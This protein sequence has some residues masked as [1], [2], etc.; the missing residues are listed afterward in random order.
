MDMRTIEIDVEVHK[1]IEMERAS[2]AESPNAV[3]RR[4]LGIDRPGTGRLKEDIAPL[5]WAG[6]GVELP[7]GTELTM[8]YNGRIHAG[9][10]EDGAWVVE[11]GRF[12]SPSAAAKAVART[13]GGAQPTLDGWRYWRVRRPGD[14]GWRRLR[15]LRGEDGRSFAGPPRDR[16]AAEGRG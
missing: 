14:T 4:L 6:K 13:R 5:P 7:H 2:F 11:G 1:R 15:S 8:E 16:P 12:R 10:I 3:L 9:R